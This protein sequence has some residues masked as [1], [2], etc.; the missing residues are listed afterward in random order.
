MSIDDEGNAY[1]HLGNVIKGRYPRHSFKCLKSDFNLFSRMKPYKM[2]PTHNVALLQQ[3]NSWPI[4]TL[5]CEEMV[6]LFLPENM[7]PP[8]WTRVR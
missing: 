5:A 6:Y 2:Q 4:N 7:V 8:F 1:P 3:H